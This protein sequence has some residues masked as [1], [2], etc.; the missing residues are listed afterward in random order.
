[1]NIYI[2]N[3]LESTTTE[4]ANPKKINIVMEVIYI[5]I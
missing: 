2:K 3:E 1:M 4:I 5:S